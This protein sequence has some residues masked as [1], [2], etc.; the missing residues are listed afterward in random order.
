MPGFPWH[1]L[2]L[3]FSPYTRRLWLCHVARRKGF[4]PDALLGSR[5]TDSDRSGSHRDSEPLLV[6]TLALPKQLVEGSVR[7]VPVGGGIRRARSSEPC[8]Q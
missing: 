2:V 3:I 5:S 8:L 4:L 6:P 7:S 1:F